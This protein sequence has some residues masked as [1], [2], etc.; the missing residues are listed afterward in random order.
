MFFSDANSETEAKNRSNLYND[1]F[2]LV[3]HLQSP[4]K[5]VNICLWENKKLKR[6]Q[7]DAVGIVDFVNEQWE[8]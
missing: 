8:N 5:E 2:R 6:S 1:P 3:F 4:A 7:E